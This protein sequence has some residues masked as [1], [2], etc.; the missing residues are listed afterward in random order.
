MSTSRDSVAGKKVFFVQPN[1]VVQKEMV[2]ELVG[3]E[4]DVSLI[5]NA[6]DATK[7]FERYPDCIAFLNI[8]DGLSEEEWVQFVGRVQSNPSLKSVKIGILTYNP[9]PRLA[10]KYLIDLMV[11][12]GFIRLSL[13]L[14]ESTAIVLKVLEANEARG[15]R[16]YLRVHCNQNTR[17]NFRTSTDLI[18]G[19]ILDISS[20]GMSCILNPDKSWAAHTVFESIQLKLKASLCL[21]T[22]IVMGSRQDTNSRATVYVVLF[23]P[24]TPPI[25]KEKIRVFMQWVLQSSIDSQLRENEKEL[26]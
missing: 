15:R 5:H 13:K 17:L 4:F 16:R 20:V 24:K 3:Q 7:I 19:R 25:Q 21:I 26:G 14:A 23:D 9:D 22:G 2:A 1:S 12:C 6:S 10:K 11:P 8:D 18:D